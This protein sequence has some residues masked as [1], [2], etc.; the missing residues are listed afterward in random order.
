MLSTD[1]K[2]VITTFIERVLNDRALEQA[3]AIVAEDFIELDLI[4]GT[5]DGTRGVER[6]DPPDANVISRHALGHR[7]DGS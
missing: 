3:Y 4:P 5:G 1:N 7:R 6:R 2:N